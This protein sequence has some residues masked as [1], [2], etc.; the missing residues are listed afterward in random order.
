MPIN[1]TI[2]YGQSVQALYSTIS[3]ATYGNVQMQ[4]P[5]LSQGLPTNILLP[6]IIG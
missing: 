3:D 2:I 4:G 1:M 5:L 6:T